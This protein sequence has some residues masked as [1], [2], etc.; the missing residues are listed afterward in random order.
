MYTI[1]IMF[2][3]EWFDK[4]KIN[5]DGNCLFRSISVF[6]NK[7]L[8]NVR[9][10]K[11]GLCVN[12]N[13]KEVEEE[14]SQSIRSMVTTF[15]KFHSD[16]FK[17]DIQID[18]EYYSSLEDRI[19]KMKNDG[20]YGSLVECYIMTKMFNFQVN[21]FVK[22]NNGY[23]LISKVGKN[24]SKLK[25]CNLLFDKNHY[26]LLN[27]KKDYEKEYNK[28]QLLWSRENPTVNYNELLEPDSDIEYEI[29]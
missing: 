18:N 25:I 19:N 17:N 22:G 21:I 10:N 5:A 24:T 11:S 28:K 27:L 7:E 15:M 6:L 23:N 2:N 29:I 9:R 4:I 13:L 14:Q 1:L 12:K 20:E 3:V 8:Y 16:K 26:E